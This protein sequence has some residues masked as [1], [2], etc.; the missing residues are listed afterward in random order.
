MTNPATRISEVQ[1]KI[2]AAAHEVDRD[3]DATTLIAVIGLVILITPTVLIV[4]SII[5]SLG[6]VAKALATGEA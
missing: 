6:P 1:A 3:P 2:A 5:N 4:E